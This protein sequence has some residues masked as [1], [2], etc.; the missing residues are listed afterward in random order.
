MSPRNPAPMGRHRGACARRRLG[1]AACATLPLILMFAC[2]DVAAAGRQV[3][4]DGDVRKAEMVLAK[5]RLLYEAAAADD[6]G[7]Y[8]RLAS[9]LYPDLFVKVSELHQGDVSTDL[10]TAV[11][12]AEQVGR[13]WSAGGAAL[14]DCGSERPDIY[15]PLCAGLRGGTGRHLLLAKSRL[16]ARWAEAVLI[17]SRGEAGPETARTLAEITEARAND[18]LI[19]ELIVKAL[20]TLEALPQ[21]PKPSAVRA[22]VSDDAD[23]EFADALSEVGTLL[24]WLPRSPTFY[25]L[26]SARDAYRDGLWWHHKARLAKRLVISAKNFAPDPLADIRLDAEQVTA[27]AQANWS[28]AARHARLAERYLSQPPR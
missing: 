8:R 5:L 27:V 14:A 26:L 18:R 20:K 11:F 7:A 12:L 10:S 21:P 25:Q 23:A 28:S 17:N 15:A 24:A 16:H 22:E 19:S 4:G 6:A 1:V 9:K 2:V 13:T 3:I